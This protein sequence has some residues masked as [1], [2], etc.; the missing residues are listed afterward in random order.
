MNNWTLVWLLNR[1]EL[2]CIIEISGIVSCGWWRWTGV[3]WISGG[4][5]S[6]DPHILSC[7]YRRLPPLP[8]HGSSV[9]S[10]PPPPTCG[11]LLT[12]FPSPMIAAEIKIDA[13]GGWTF[14][15]PFLI[16]L[17][18]ELRCFF[19]HTVSW[20]TSSPPF[21]TLPVKHGSGQCLKVC[22]PA[23]SVWKMAA[24]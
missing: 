1:W 2:Q 13:S 16:K 5:L 21:D 4:C 12:P 3:L 18:E 15:K 17:A 19:L 10:L 20:Q 24:R 8:P 7:L 23:V 11:L 9:P 6:W 22:S 14:P